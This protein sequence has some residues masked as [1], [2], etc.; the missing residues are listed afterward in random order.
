MLFL[1]R[2]KQVKI[3]C[4]LASSL[5]LCPLARILFSL[6]LMQ[7]H[8]HISAQ[9]T[10]TLDGRKI[11]FYTLVWR[12]H[13]LH[14]NT[15]SNVKFSEYFPST[16]FKFSIPYDLYNSNRIFQNILVS[17]VIYFVCLHPCI[18]LYIRTKINE[19]VKKL[20]QL[21]INHSWTLW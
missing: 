2:N 19:E 13:P 21:I 14:L 16:Q 6:I 10:L 1:N 20:N 17:I 4:L 18:M 12:V 7:L 15:S 5:H 8:M 11:F 9:S 3:L